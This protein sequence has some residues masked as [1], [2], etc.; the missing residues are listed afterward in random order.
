MAH[1]PVVAFTAAVL[2]RDDLGVLALFDDLADD[3]SALDGGAAVREFVA[4]R[5]EKH[6]GESGFR[7][8]FDVEFFHVDNITFGYLVLFAAGLEDYV[9]HKLSLL[10]PKKRSG[11]YAAVPRL[12]SGNMRV[13]STGVFPGQ[14]LDIVM[15]RATIPPLRAVVPAATFLLTLLFAAAL[16]TA[17]IYSAPPGEQLGSPASSGES[18]GVPVKPDAKPSS[19]A[20]KKEF[21]EVIEG[22]LAAFRAG[23]YTKAY[24]YA[25]APIKDMFP[26]SEF[27][28][29]VKTA[30]P[31]IAHSSMT[32]YGLAFDVGDEAVINVRIENAEKKSVLYQ[33]MLQK[34]DGKW[35]ISGVSE[36][37]S[38]G[39]SV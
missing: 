7:A 19:D 27:E 2:E 29:M 22:Q 30:Y 1:R 12:A 8:G 11:S 13:F 5:V 4:V 14:G 23:E 25:A 20:L 32:E 16:P 15:R 18:A 21:T 10:L 6:F 36:V 35:K 28:T 37:K 31:V 26:A 9:C 38:S 17:W 3:G 34:E 24:S 39:L 33:Y